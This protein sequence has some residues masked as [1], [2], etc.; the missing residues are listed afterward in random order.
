MKASCAHCEGRGSIT[1]FSEITR[2]CPVCRRASY[3]A[4][5]RE[6]P[7]PVAFDAPVVTVDASCLRELARP[8]GGR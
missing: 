2:P 7:L 4:V 3:G 8:G 6:A 1:P 5:R